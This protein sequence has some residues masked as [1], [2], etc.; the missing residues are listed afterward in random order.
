MSHFD[1][2]HFLLLFRLV[3]L[4]SGLDSMKRFADIFSL[5]LL[6]PPC[7]DAARKYVNMFLYPSLANQRALFFRSDIATTQNLVRLSLISPYLTSL[8][9]VCINHGSTVSLFHRLRSQ[10]VSTKYL[11]VSGSGASFKGSDG[12][13]LPGLDPRHRSHV[14]SFVAKTASWG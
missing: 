1:V 2:F 9:S 5:S 11:C 13:P 8:S 4:L 3:R 10:T 12:A 6:P 14:P 7:S